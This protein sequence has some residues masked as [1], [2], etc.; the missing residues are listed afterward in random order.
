MQEG[1]ISR[2]SKENG[3]N[4]TRNEGHLGLVMDG[5]VFHSSRQF[6]WNQCGVN[7]GGCSH[8][9]LARP[10]EEYT[11]AC[12]NHYV[13][14]ATYKSCSGNLRNFCLRMCYDKPEDGNESAFTNSNLANNIAYSFKCHMFTFYAPDDIDYFW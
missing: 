3:E 4:R 5:K 8:L 7:N 11:C 14:D 9:C 2:A 13:L 1:T 12:P 6:G 10:N